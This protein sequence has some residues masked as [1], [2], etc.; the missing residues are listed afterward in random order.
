VAPLPVPAPVA[1]RAASRPGDISTRQAHVLVVEDD[2]LNQTIVC[3]LLRHGGH[4]TTPASDGASALRLIAETDF[5]MVLMDWQM[6]DMDGL[7]V[8]RRMR[9]GAAGAWAQQVPVVALTANA[10]S[11]DRAACLAAGM[12]DFLSKPVQNQLLLDAVAR[13]TQQPEAAQ[14]AT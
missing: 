8:T 4:R 9:A 5:D 14:P 6:P 11:E 2:P 13:W 12:N 3:S 10:F 1:A 7:E